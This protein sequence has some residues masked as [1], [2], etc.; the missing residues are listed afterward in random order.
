MLTEI[1]D[2]IIADV[3]SAYPAAFPN[4]PLVHENG[5]N[6][7]NNPPPQFVELEVAVYDAQQSSIAASSPGTRYHG[8]VYVYFHSREGLGTRAGT[9]VFDWFIGRFAY[10]Y[11][12]PI[13][14]QPPR[15]GPTLP[16]PGWYRQALTIPFFTK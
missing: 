7:S 3:I 11:L 14:F 8:A 12:S 10:R 2:T 4:Y 13:Q 16:S 1:R 9:Q 15:P 5:P 6:N